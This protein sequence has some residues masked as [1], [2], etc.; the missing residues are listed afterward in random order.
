[1]SL[2]RDFFFR[3]ICSRDQTDWIWFRISY[4]SIFV[5]SNNNRIIRH[6]IL[7]EIKIIYKIYKKKVCCCVF[8]N[9]CCELSVS[10]RTVST[11]WPKQSLQLSSSFVLSSICETMVFAYSF[12][13]DEKKNTDLQRK[14]KLKNRSNLFRRLEQFI[15]WHKFTIVWRKNKKSAKHSVSI[16]IMWMCLSFEKQAKKWDAVRSSKHVCQ[17][18]TTYSPGQ[19]ILK[20]VSPFRL[21]FSMA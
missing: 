3:P 15:T 18:A 11:E 21:L 4:S 9:W 7:F 1:M 6:F 2:I 12:S 8:F 5:I 16:C 20:I 10:R 19:W 14:I 17:S 13:D